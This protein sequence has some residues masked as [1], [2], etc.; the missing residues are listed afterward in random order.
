MGPGTALRGLLKKAG[1]KERTGCDC[2]KYAR[3]MDQA[4]VEWCEDNQPTILRW[5]IR[6]ARR[7]RLP[8]VHAV[9]YRFIQEAISIAKQG[10]KKMGKKKQR[11]GR[12]RPAGV[13]VRQ[14]VT[15]NGPK[16][17]VDFFQ[18]VYV[19]NLDRREDRWKEFL[20]RLPKDWPFKDPVRFSAVDG[21]ACPAPDWWKQGGGAWGCHRSHLRLIEDALNRG[22]DSILL[23]EDDA[24][25]PEDFA[26]KV[27]EFLSH[28]PKDWGMVYL[29]GQHLFVNT[30]PPKKINPWVYQ[31]YNVNRTHAFALRGDTMRKV[32][33]HLNKIDWNPGH[34]IDHHLGRFHQQRSAPV[35]VPKEWLVGQAGGYSNI[36]GREKETHFW[37]P[38]EILAG[39]DPHEVPFVAV[40][41]LHSSGSSCLAGVL[42]HLG[43]HLGNNLV[44]YYGK[45]PDKNCGFE[46]KGLMDLCE[47]AI[48]FPATEYKQARGKIWSSLQKWINTRRR[49]AHAK[50]TLPAG[51]YPMLCRMGNQ[52]HSLCGDKLLVVHINRPFE[53]SVESLVKRSKNGNPD[54]IRKHQAWLEE[55]KQQLLAK[56]PEGQK[57]TV[58]Y[59]DLLEDPAR[60]IQR[61]VA[62]LG[63]HPSEDQLNKARDWVKPEKRHVVHA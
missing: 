21:K 37:Q 31:P 22:V 28:V 24:L 27:G 34:H 59:A 45:D 35:Y 16:P 6:S 44:G 26:A 41:G 51:K 3:K 11:A 55:G 13:A 58:E 48:P 1:F 49:E 43:L 14:P 29:G 62:F 18:E 25:F 10:D 50:G 30:H 46:A 8:F 38:A 53:E 39:I 36:A 12:G 7:Q 63:V 33:R 52:L 17:F 54:Q 20:D 60:E 56:L 15:T 40:F 47:A 61:L 57:I 4:G 23:L 9:A 32:Y 2:K 42:Y 5:L 19:V